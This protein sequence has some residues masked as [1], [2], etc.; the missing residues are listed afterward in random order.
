MRT[1]A[2]P[3]DVGEELQQSG[4]GPRDYSAVGYFR[5]NARRPKFAPDEQAVLPPN[6]GP[7]SSAPA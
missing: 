1:S 2:L 5:A 4:P 3:G 7:T 6:L